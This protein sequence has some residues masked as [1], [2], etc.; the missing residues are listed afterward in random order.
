MAVFAYCTVIGL[1]QSDKIAILRNRSMFEAEFELKNISIT[2]K[3]SSK[4]SNLI[5]KLYFL[6]KHKSPLDLYLLSAC[7]MQYLLY[8]ERKS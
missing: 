1:E 2:C 7:L 5:T 4:Y 3:I 8:N 6:K